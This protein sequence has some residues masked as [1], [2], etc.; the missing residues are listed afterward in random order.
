ML[1]STSVCFDLSVFEL[2]LPLAVG[3][4][5]ILADHALALPRLAGRER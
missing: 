2:F 1:A 5:V 4:A 3:G